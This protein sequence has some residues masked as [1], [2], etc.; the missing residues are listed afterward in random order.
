MLSMGCAF[1]AQPCHAASIAFFSRSSLLSFEMVL[2]YA[3]LSS[4]HLKDAAE[5]ITAAAQKMS[6]KKQEQKCSGTNLVHLNE[7]V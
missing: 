3:H 2:R 7:A 1:N 4:D 6:T 5:R